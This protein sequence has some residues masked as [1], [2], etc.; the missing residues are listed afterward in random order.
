MGAHNDEIYGNELGLSKERLK[1]L[2]EAGL[3]N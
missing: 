1:Q 2:K 3:Y